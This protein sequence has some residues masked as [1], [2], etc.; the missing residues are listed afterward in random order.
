MIS[1]CYSLYSQE[2]QNSNEIPLIKDAPPT[3]RT[4]INQTLHVITQLTTS[5]EHIK[6]AIVQNT[7]AQPT[8]KRT[9]NR[10]ITTQLQTEN[11][12]E[13]LRV[14]YPRSLT[15]TPRRLLRGYSRVS[16][17]DVCSMPEVT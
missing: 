17:F 3:T 5:Y 12:P 8:T 16:E 15:N 10:T 11:S 14:Q 13:Q 4:I 1:N 2:V 7:F 9:P 6:N